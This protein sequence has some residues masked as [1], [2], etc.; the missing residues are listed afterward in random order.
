MQPAE[1]D[2]RY[3]G[4]RDDDLLLALGRQLIAGSLGA[5]GASDDETRQAGARWFDAYVQQL[6]PKLCGNAELRSLLGREA[7]D[8]NALFCL[9]FDLIFTPH[10]GVPAGALASRILSL[11]VSKICPD[12]K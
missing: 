10:L 12:W 8:R 11:G 4:M 1:A 3:L 6:R 9:I 5:K 2:F 7:Q